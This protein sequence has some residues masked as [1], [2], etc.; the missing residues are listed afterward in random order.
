VSSERFFARLGQRIV[1]ILAT[2]TMSGQLYD[3]DTRLRPSGAAGLLVSS[4]DAFDKYQRDSAWTWEHQALVRARPVAGCPRAAEKFN[5]IR[6]AVLSQERDPEQLRT[7]VLAMRERMLEHLGNKAGEGRFQ[8]KQDPGG[9][10]DVEFMV[11]YSVLRWACRYGELTRYTD[12]ARLLE[13]LAELELM[14]AGDAGL[15]REAYL[16]Y[17]AAAH[18]QSLR[19]EKSIVDAKEFDELREGVID[20]WNRWFERPEES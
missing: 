16:A 4:M 11:Q 6:H 13:T 19:K 1:H 14:P 3:V 20:I 18:R 17:R 7:D 10:V 15:L 12:N 2:R 9:I 5:G 8:L